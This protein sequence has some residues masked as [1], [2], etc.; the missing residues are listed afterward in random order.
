MELLNLP[1]GCRTFGKWRT[2]RQ[3]RARLVPVRI[4]RSGSAAPDY[5]CVLPTRAYAVCCS[6]SWRVGADL[7]ASTSLLRARMTTLIARLVGRPSCGMRFL[8]EDFTHFKRP[9]RRGLPSRLGLRF[10]C[11]AS[12]PRGHQSGSGSEKSFGYDLPPQACH[13]SKKIGSWRVN[14]LPLLRFKHV[15]LPV[16]RYPRGVCRG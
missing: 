2:G 6:D 8:R 9:A 14:S 16:P 5:F 15:V 11:P 10:I 13:A 4:A 7:S 1:A 3:S 12:P